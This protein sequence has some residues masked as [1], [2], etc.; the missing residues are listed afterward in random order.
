[1]P[2]VYRVVLASFDDYTD[3][4]LALARDPASLL[5]LRAKLGRNR[6]S[7]PLTGPARFTRQ[8]ETAYALMW[9]RRQRGKMAVSFDLT[10]PL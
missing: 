1:M 10:G 2:W 7:A 4:A 5:A 8:L 9:E 6:G 3:L